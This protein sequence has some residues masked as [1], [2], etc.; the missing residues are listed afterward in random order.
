MNSIT[1]VSSLA[2]TA[3][4]LVDDVSDKVAAN[5]EL[6][7]ELADVKDAV[8]TVARR[9]DGLM[10]FVSSYRRLTRLPEPDKRRFPVADLLADVK[11]IVIAQ[12]SDDV[13]PITINVEPKALE[14]YADRQMI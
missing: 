2:R 4:D 9:A 11:R 1:P 5:D 12:W 6:V 3:V 14:L 7:A 10:N 13:I 8:N